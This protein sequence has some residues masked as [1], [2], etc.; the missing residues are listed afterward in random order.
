MIGPLPA[1]IMISGTTE[2]VRHSAI[3]LR[4][5]PVQLRPAGPRRCAGARASAARS[6]RPNRAIS[7]SFGRISGTTRA[8][9]HAHD[10]RR[11][12]DEQVG[13]HSGLATTS[14]RC[15]NTSAGPARTWA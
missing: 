6:P 8:R 3:R 7:A 10:E 4:S 12:E 13:R 2:L 1:T 11:Q 9:V 15:R 14:R 5:T